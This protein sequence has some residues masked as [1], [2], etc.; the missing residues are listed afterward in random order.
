ML[1]NMDHPNI[2]K[3]KDHLMDDHNLYIIMGYCEG[4]DL[5]AKIK[6]ASKKGEFEE[7]RVNF[8]L[9]LRT[10][11]DAGKSRSARERCQELLR[12]SG[13]HVGNRQELL[14]TTQEVPGGVS[15]T[16]P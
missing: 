2:V 5:H 4:G 15:I 14:A 8:H 12:S 7:E 1:S 13:H 6:E 3:Y 10:A 11:A 16:R 9:D